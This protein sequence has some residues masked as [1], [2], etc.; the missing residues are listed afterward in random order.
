[1]S[2]VIYFE[3]IQF[4]HSS[5]QFWKTDCT[6][7]RFWFRE[8][9]LAKRQ[10][11]VNLTE[12]LYFAL[13]LCSVTLIVLRPSQPSPPFTITRSLVCSLIRPSIRSSI[14]NLYTRCRQ[15]PKEIIREIMFSPSGFSE[16]K[17]HK[18]RHCFFKHE[19]F[20]YFLITRAKFVNNVFV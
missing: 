10:I 16:S 17:S 5:S 2:R 20:I 11:P 7:Q 1:M 8:F 18:N 9:L 13:S 3:D 4:T 14:Q 12:L 6:V 15:K 19:I